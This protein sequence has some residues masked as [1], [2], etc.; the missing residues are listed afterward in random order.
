MSPRQSSRR[1]ALRTLFGAFPGRTSALAGLALLTGILPAAFAVLVGVLVSQLPG[2]TRAGFASASGHRAVATL[3]AIAV[4]LVMIELADSAREVINTDLYRRL[5][6]N[7]LGRVM[8]AALSR[9]DLRLFDDPG[10]AAQLDKG[11]QLARFGPGELVSGLST[12]WTVR[13]QGLAAAALVGY[14]W[15]AA[16]VLLTAVWLVVARAMQASYYRADPFWTDPLRRARYLQRIGLLSPW[17]KEVRVFG[18]AGWL[19]GQYAAEWSAVM[20]H[21]WRARR[22]DH[23]RMVMLGSLVLGAHVAVLLQL[24]RAASSGSLPVPALIVVLQGI[25]GMASIA[26]L[27]GDTWIEN[28]SVPV[29]DVLSLERA[30]GAGEPRAAAGAQPGAALPA[31]GL[32]R[33][34][35]VFSEVSFGYPGGGLVLEAFDLRLQA[36]RS[37]AIVGLNGAGKTTLVKLLT[38]LC[39]PTT[40]TISIDGIELSDLDLASWRRQLAVIFQDFVRYELPLADNIG[41]G[42]MEQPDLSPAALAEIVAQAGATELIARLPEGTGTTLSPRFPGGVDISGGQWQ[43]VAFARALMA[44]RSGA[45][46]LV[47]DEPTAHLDVRAEAEFFSRFLELTAGLTTIV[48]SHRFSTVRRA[49]RILVLSGGRVTEDGSHDDLIAASGQ[50]AQMF[51]LQARNYTG[52]RND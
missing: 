51:A 4:A 35:I 31:V 12:Q 50:Y 37:V 3:I 11:V 18:L 21:L 49:D 13:A 29:P 22:A 17:A 20:V 38:G 1:A 25:F 46:V 5:D 45:Q 7:L 47:M 16:A 32:P 19:V 40:G 48:I 10:L 24:A 44:V 8:T 41:F 36:G 30:A 43:R 9:D 2:L 27:Q 42:W 33:S 6:R 26:S 28:G 39:Q 23:R 52:D 14:Y 34:E 15:P